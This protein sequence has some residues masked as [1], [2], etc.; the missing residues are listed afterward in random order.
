M[1]P[2]TPHVDAEQRPRGSALLARACR[3]PVAVVVLSTYV[4]IHWG[5]ARPHEWAVEVAFLGAHLVAAETLAAPHHRG[6]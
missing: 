1:Q 2:T 3:W 4:L 6:E 5:V